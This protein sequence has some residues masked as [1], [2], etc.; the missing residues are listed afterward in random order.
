MLVSRKLNIFRRI[1]FFILFNLCILSI[2]SFFSIANFLFHSSEYSKMYLYSNIYTSIIFPL[3]S[4][5]LYKIHT[6]IKSL[7]SNPFTENNIKNFKIIYRC[8]MIITLL[9]GLFTYPL[10]SPDTGLEILKTSY[11]KLKPS[12]ILYFVLAVVSLTLSYIFEK[13]VEIKNE[14]DLTV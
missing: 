2:I 3:F 5:I 14:N 12:C 7:S 13:A 9:N 1:I 11:G 10:Y 8:M 4:V 6:I